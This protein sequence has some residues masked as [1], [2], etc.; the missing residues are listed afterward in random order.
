MMLPAG[1]ANIA[2]F[3][4]PGTSVGY[5]A[6]G[7]KNLHVETIKGAAHYVAEEKRECVSG[8]H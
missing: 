7:C 6:H 2:N 4:P 3:G 8:T 1:S 5:R